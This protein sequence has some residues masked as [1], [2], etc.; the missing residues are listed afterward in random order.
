MYRQYEEI[1]ERGGVKSIPRTVL[2]TNIEALESHPQPMPRR[3][4]PFSTI[5][6]FLMMHNLF[7]S[8]NVCAIDGN[9]GERLH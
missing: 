9:E 6:Y 2:E 3:P 4:S 7:R 8:T 1:K 5:R